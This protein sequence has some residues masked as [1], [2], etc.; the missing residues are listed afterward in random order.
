MRCNFACQP[1]FNSWLRLSSCPIL[2]T[3]APGMRAYNAVND[4]GHTAAR[5]LWKNIYL[6]HRPAPAQ[7]QF[8]RAHSWTTRRTVTKG[9]M[10]GNSGFSSPQYVVAHS[11]PASTS[12]V[13][14]FPPAPLPITEF[15]FFFLKASL[16]TA[17]PAISHDLHSGT[18]SFAWVSSSY[19]L[20]ATAILPLVGRVADIFGRRTVRNEHSRHVPADALTRFLFSPSHSSWQDLPSVEPLG[21]WK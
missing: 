2:L 17:L 7:T 1:H 8:L 21:P 16:G 3:A 18:T 20:A 10:V 19:T 9:H 12:S 13:F 15:F 6:P 4:F 5:D 14:Q 11:S